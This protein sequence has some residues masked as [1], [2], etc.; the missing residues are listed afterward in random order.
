MS[1]AE[2]EASD[3][4]GGGDASGA[5]GAVGEYTGFANE[6]VFVSVSAGGRRKCHF[7]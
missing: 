2:W 7:K 6:N 5:P 1:G 4:P 3:P